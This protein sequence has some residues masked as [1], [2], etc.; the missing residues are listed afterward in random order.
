MAL[1]EAEVI[2]LIPGLVGD[3]DQESGEPVSQ[4][5]LVQARAQALWDLHADKARRPGLRLLYALRSAVDMLIGRLADR[6]DEAVLDATSDEADVVANRVAQRAALQQA[7]DRAEA[8][9]RS[10]RV[11]AIGRASIDEMFPGGHPWGRGWPA[12]P[13][14]ETRRAWS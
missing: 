5:G 8:E 9:A 4:G 13:V 1:T 11:A 7:I 2:A 12:W 3:I 6:V 14:E 10:N